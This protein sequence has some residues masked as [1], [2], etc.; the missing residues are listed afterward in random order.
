M[1]QAVV[2]WETGITAGWYRANQLIGL[3]FSPLSLQVVEEHT[4]QNWKL[5]FK[6]WQGF[7]MTTEECA[8]GVILSI[9]PDEGGFFEILESDWLRELG[10]DHHHFLK[11]SR[12]F[13]I[14]SYD[15]II[16]V[17]AW[18][19]VIEKLDHLGYPEG[20]ARIQIDPSEVYTAPDDDDPFSKMLRMKLASRS[21]G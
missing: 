13:V 6:V 7:R 14:C 16:E 21:G 15:E 3:A 18:D 19:C 1:T 5:T 10:R 8:W 11:T 17:A 9:L 20:Q 12:H 4:E 2:P